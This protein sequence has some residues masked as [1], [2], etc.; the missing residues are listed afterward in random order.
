MQTST[1]G[2]ATGKSRILALLGEGRCA[3]A[4]SQAQ[5]LIDRDASD[6]D[7]QYTYGV[8]LLMNGEHAAARLW[9]QKAFVQSP[10]DAVYAANLGIACLRAGQTDDA[11]RYLNLAVDLNPDY[12][13]A[14][15]NLGSACLQAKQMDAAVNHFRALCRQV[16][17]SVEYLCALAD[18]TRESGQWR[19]AMKL[20][21]KVLARDPRCVRALTNSAAMLMNAGQTEDAIA[22]CREA[23]AL[24]GKN[25]VLHKNLG[26]CL[27]QME[28]LDEA[29]EAYADAYDLKPESPQLCVAIGKVWLDTHELAEAATWLQRALHL[30]AENIAA[31][32]GLIDIMRENGNMEQ[33]LEMLQPLQ[34]KAPDDCDLLMTAADTLWEDGDAEGALRQLRRLCELQPQR[35]ALRGKIGQILSSAGKVE[36]ALAEY[37]AGL[38]QNP[39]CVPALN[40]LATSQRGT[41]EAEYA[42]TMEN[43]LASPKR[44][45]GSQ[46]A[47]YSGLAFY[48]DGIKDYAKA[49][50]C[51]RLANSKQWESRSARGWH[52]DPAEHE[53]HV[54][55]LIATFNADYFT[56]LRSR[57]IGSDDET[58]TFIVAMPRS[59]T[60]LTEQILGRHTQILGIGE[61]NFANQSFTAAIRKANGTLAVE[62]VRDLHGNGVLQLAQRYLGRLQELKDKSGMPEA[63]R[64]VDKMP[65]NYSLVGWILTLFPRARIIHC[66]RDAR[67]V[68]LSCWMTQFGSIR[69]ACHVDHLVTRIRQYQRIMDHWRSVVPDRFIEMDYETLVANQEVESRRLLDYLGV[70]W[71]PQCLQ[72]YASDRLVRTA[73]ITQVRQPIYNQS[74]ARWKRYEPYLGDLFSQITP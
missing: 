68:A 46:S 71:Q 7:A 59:G 26:D 53:Q 25:Y 51:M 39:R 20:Y 47:L 69:W 13:Q 12:T 19:K 55:Q 3:E 30:D 45:A 10:G 24:D 40:G 27:L 70:P 48:Y 6:R 21:K 50:D 56:D 43:M 63:L 52:Y 62:R 72:F 9:L 17:D 15:Y 34:A 14:R 41:L 22:R 64:V 35:A 29:M 42:A 60:T 44:H 31:H 54:S 58:P 23:I 8:A 1:A 37:R 66:R 5:I 16:P 18:A 28:R 11:L 74:V 4:R 61:R 2:C 49:A 38:Q 73:S 32:C 67:D 57:G 33:A 36:Q 65:D